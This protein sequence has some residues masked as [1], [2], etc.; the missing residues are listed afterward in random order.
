MSYLL[1]LLRHFLPASENARID[2]YEAGTSRD[3]LRGRSVLV[4]LIR[5]LPLW[6]CCVHLVTA[7][8]VHY[9]IIINADPCTLE[10]LGGMVAK[11]IV[12]VALIFVLVI[13]VLVFLVTVIFS[14]LKTLKLPPHFV[15]MLYSE[16]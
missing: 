13:L 6:W 15:R 9:K 5:P 11:S 3:E 2:Q 8:F 12:V 14:S 7:T 10:K 4:D 1:A 16:H